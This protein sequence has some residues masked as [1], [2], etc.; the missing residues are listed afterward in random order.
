MEQIFSKMS[1]LSY[2]A[3]MG[4]I[5]CFVGNGAIRFPAFLRLLESAGGFPEKNILLVAS[6]VRLIGC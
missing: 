4:M 3:E 6:V 5:Y 1:I 2:R